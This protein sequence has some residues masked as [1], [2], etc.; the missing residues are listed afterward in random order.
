MK[1]ELGALAPGILE[2]LVKQGFRPNLAQRQSLEAL[3]LDF[4]ASNRLFVRGFIPDSAIERIRKRLVKEVGKIVSKKEAPLAAFNPGGQKL[5][6]EQMQANA[7]PFPLE[8][9]P[10]QS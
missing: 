6:P 1:L 9:K 10:T 8:N 5:T 7:W 3:D 2:Q 4:H